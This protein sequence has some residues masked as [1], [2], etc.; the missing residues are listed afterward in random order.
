MEAV[1]FVGVLPD[2]MEKTVLSV[3]P[4][5]SLAARVPVM[6][7]ES[8]AP[9]P[10]VSPEMVAGSSTAVI[11]REMVCV[12]LPPRSSVTVTVKESLPL[13]LALGL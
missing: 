5:G 10:E 9:L 8:S 1:P 12:V 11:V 3:R 13:K 6:A 4:S 2:S 7:D